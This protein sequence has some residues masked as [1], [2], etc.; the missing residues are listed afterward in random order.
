MDT[1]LALYQAVQGLSDD[2]LGRLST[3]LVLLSFG[4]FSIDSLDTA[5]S[6][7]NRVAADLELGMRDWWT[8]D[9]EF[10][11]LLRKDQLEAV[12]IESGASLRMGKVKSYGKKEMVDALAQYLARTANPTTT[13][14][15]R[16]QKGRNWLP[17]AM[18]FPA[19]T[20]QTMADN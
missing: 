1:P 3:L 13:L 2:D 4:Q 15:E 19:H 11:A 16:D 7:F 10:L 12:A 8:P 18:S 6:L 20:A 9:A 14:D 5:E 17:R